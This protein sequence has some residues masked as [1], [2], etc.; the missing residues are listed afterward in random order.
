MSPT[1]R[2]A[3]FFDL[4]K[5]V[6]A[7]S[8]TLAFSQP[9]FRSGLLTPGGAARSI[10]AQLGYLTVGASHDQMER[11]KDRLGQVVRGWDVARTEEI[12][13]A[14]LEDRIRPV[15]YQEAIDLIAEHHAAG[16]DVVMV[17][18]SSETL[19]RPIAELLGV[20]HVIA[21]RGSVVDG[22]YT[23]TLDYYAYGPTKRTGIEE[24]ARTEGYDLASSHAY[25]DS[26]TDIPML[27]AVGHPVA[28]NPDR[29]LRRHAA[30]QGWAIRDFARPVTVGPPLHRSSAALAVAGLVVGGLV[31]WRLLRHWRR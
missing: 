20:D 14:A 5:T 17:S 23:G 26:A 27:E 4:D 18:A 9:F 7:G 30:E 12:I 24:L 1:N 29:T 21:S 25:S 16:E 22:R 19:V 28:V 8:S 6:I 2:P 3:A 11:M 15:V 31:G 13:A 10:M